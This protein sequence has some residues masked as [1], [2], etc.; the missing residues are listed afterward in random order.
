ML[1]LRMDLLLAAVDSLWIMF[2]SSA[3]QIRSSSM[4]LQR[5]ISSAWAMTWS[6]CKWRGSVGVGK[7]QQRVTSLCTWASMASARKLRKIISCSM[8][9][10]TGLA[11]HPSLKPRCMP[12]EEESKCPALHLYSV[13]AMRPC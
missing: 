13:R 2:V 4:V 8:L 10:S 6:L 7:A 12:K 9:N 5:L 3:K 1:L 11:G